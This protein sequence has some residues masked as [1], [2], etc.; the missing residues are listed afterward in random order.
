METPTGSE[1]L[2]RTYKRIY[3]ACE[4]CRTTKSKCER[5]A[6]DICLKC[7]R[8]QRECIFPT[9]RS[10]KRVKLGQLQDA[11]DRSRETWRFRPGGVK[12]A[13]R[14][15]DIRT[16][17]GLPVTSNSQHVD[18][19]NTVL[20][21]EGLDYST[22]D[23]VVVNPSDAVGLLLREAGHGDAEGATT[24]E[25]PVSHHVDAYAE[26]PSGRTPM[27]LMRDPVPQQILE[28]WSQHRFIRQGWFTEREAVG[29][30]Q[31]YDSSL[32]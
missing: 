11:E 10:V 2:Q 7:R 26:T 15:T 32:T 1:P 31:A 14:Q 29:Y 24:L 23:G 3:K 30:I 20:C 25:D 18:I 12:D 4:S 16:H 21:P 27:L 19:P 17:G 22:V 28:L 8:E 13:A 9:Q 5:D 6:S